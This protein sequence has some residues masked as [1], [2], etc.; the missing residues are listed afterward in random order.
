MA[1]H[2]F[3][4]FL[5]KL[6]ISF[7]HEE[8]A[9]TL[10]ELLVVIGII[11]ALAAVVIPNIAVLTGRG[12]T[13]AMSEEFSN[14]Q[15]AMDFMMVDRGI[16]GLNASPATSQND[17]KTFPNGSGTAPLEDYLRIGTTMYY[18]C[19]DG[20]GHVTVQHTSASAC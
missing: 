19:W 12:E 17:W 13:G 8:P 1:L 6:R 7:V 16:T 11:V 20:I 9:F 4:S 18:Y 2:G 3:A 5:R 14:V 10:V 15:S